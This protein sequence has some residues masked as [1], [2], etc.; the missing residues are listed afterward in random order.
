MFDIGNLTHQR[1]HL[2]L[3]TLYQL[4]VRYF[5]LAPGSRSTPLALAL[6]NLPK[7][8]RCIHFDERGL[9]FH[10]L[11]Y[12]KASK[13]PVVIIVT[14]GTA[15]ANLF[16]AIAEASAS[17]VPI[18]LLSADRPHELRDCGANQTMSQ[19][20]LFKPF[21]RWEIDLPLSDPLLPDAY[22]LSTL[23]YANH[24]SLYGPAGPVQINCMIREPS[25]SEKEVF[26]IPSTPCDYEPSS[27]TPPLSS[28]KKWAELLASYEKGIILLGA[29]A[30]DEETTPLLTLAEKLN[31]PI[32]SDILSGGRKI[33]DH[34]HHIEHADIL[35]KTTQN[36]KIEAVLQIGGSFVSKTLA[37]WISKQALPYFLVTCTPFRQDPTSQVSHKMEC[38]TDLFCLTLNSFLEKKEGPWV[39]FWKSKADIIKK[40][41][42]SLFGEDL[43]SEPFLADFFKD[44]PCL[45]LSNS[46]PIRDADLFIFPKA[47]ENFITA[48]R[49]ISGIDGNV[50]TAIGVA[51]ALNKPLVALLG[52][53]ATLHDL[54]SFAL[55][56]QCPVPIFFILINNQ[57]G[58]IFS[59]LP[60][61]KK[62]EI[63]DEFFATE[64]TYSFE[65]VA[66]MFSIPFT[67]VSSCMELKEAMKNNKTSCIIECSTSRKNNVMHHETIYKKIEEKLCSFID[68]LETLET[69]R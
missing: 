60:I 4:G 30:L 27:A 50:A 55:V 65:G 52:D 5:C 61:A 6:A 26:S 14:T 56:K 62:E 25:F 34:P 59:F 51:K 16:P 15:V 22:L 38:K 40:E 44:S 54:N 64:H 57:G 42:S 63:L 58:G 7:E 43:F 23:S 67:K 41:I 8:C 11:G 32:F 36:L 66:K 13:T 29:D 33:G 24:R 68:R 49:G 18:I 69:S 20:D 28:F 47:G 1:A 37:N 35:I 46:M 45:F 10:A 31:W 19:V 2:V 12:A 3:N 39:A 53:V 17:K 21:T 9:G 48:N